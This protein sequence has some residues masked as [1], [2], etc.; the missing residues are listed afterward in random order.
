MSFDDW[1]MYLWSTALRIGNG[2]L[3]PCTTCTGHRRPTACLIVLAG[4]H[5][6]ET[7]YRP[8]TA[9]GVVTRKGPCG[10]AIAMAL[11][12]SGCTRMGALESSRSIGWPLEDINSDFACLRQLTDASSRAPAQ[13]KI[14]RPSLRNSSTRSTASRASY[15]T[16]R[17]H[18]WCAT[19]TPTTLSTLA[20][21]WKCRRLDSQTVMHIERH[22][23]HMQHLRYEHWCRI[24][25]S[26]TRGGRRGLSPLRASV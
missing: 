26:R 15:K 22:P 2:T 10:G 5:L 4:R 24:L 9:L 21:R 8:G 20:T 12:R 16:R 19:I 17:L 6:L 23:R 14:A 18:S 1:W 3:P 25:R 7:R 11:S 13:L